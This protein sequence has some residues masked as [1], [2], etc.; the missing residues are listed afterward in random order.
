MAA[1]SGTP[2]LPAGKHFAWATAATQCCGSPGIG[3]LVSLAHSAVW[4]P[5]VVDVRTE[6]DQFARRS[7][8]EADSKT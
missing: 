4:P 6:D 3:W 8:Q 1:G 5:A 2:Q 7:A